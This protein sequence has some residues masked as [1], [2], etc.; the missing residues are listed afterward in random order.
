MS[1]EGLQRTLQMRQAGH[2]G[3]ERE[4]RQRDWESDAERRRNPGILGRFTLNHQAYLTTTWERVMQ[5]EALHDNDR[6]NRTQI[7]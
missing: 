7:K 4:Q 2:Y 6:F 1:K 3:A 5:E